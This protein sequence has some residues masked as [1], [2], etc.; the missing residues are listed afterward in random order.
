M[1][2]NVLRERITQPVLDR[3]GE[4]HP[5]SDCSEKRRRRCALSL[6]AFGYVN[7]FT[8]RNLGR[9]GGITLYK[10]N[11]EGRLASPAGTNAG[12]EF[13]TELWK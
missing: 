13:G 9:M 7:R 4:L 5:W 12:I 8:S 11:S 10:E 2:Q 1:V 3:V 6:P